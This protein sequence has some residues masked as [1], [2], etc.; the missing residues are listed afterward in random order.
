MTA[1]AALRP[2]ARGPA[3]ARGGHR[4]GVAGRRPRRRR[5]RRP[6]GRLP[7]ASSA[8]TRD[9]EDVLTVWA[10]SLSRHASAGRDGRAGIDS[11]A[12]RGRPG[13]AR[14]S[15][16]AG[17][18]SGRPGRRAGRPGRGLPERSGA[19]PDPAVEP[20]GP[21]PRG[22]EGRR[23][24]RSA[25]LR[26]A[27]GGDRDRVGLGGGR[28]ASSR[29]SGETLA[30]AGLY[31]LEVDLDR[32]CAWTER[33]LAD[34]ARQGAR[35]THEVAADLPASRAAICSAR[36]TASGGATAK[37]G[38]GRGLRPWAAVDGGRRR[39]DDDPGGGGLR[40]A[41][42]DPFPLRLEELLQA[43]EADDRPPGCDAPR[44]A[45]RTSTACRSRG[46]AWSRW[47]RA[48]R[49]P[50]RL[51]R[52]VAKS[53]WD[54]PSV[55]RRISKACRSRGSAASGSPCMIRRRAS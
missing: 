7:V 21:P 29:S 14:G 43:L 26:E 16:R 23:A 18:R 2:H 1:G 48:Q 47:P 25:R 46:S 19:G 3:G 51:L 39:R 27:A 4:E 34:A 30:D 52:F 12:A 13:L 15:R 55:A 31:A 6:T 36:S 28:A 8:V 38:R 45:N 44:V 33:A 32:E 22:A 35:R 41:E 53:G 42:P 50:P 37:R 11:I 17:R 40:G 10:P 9:E 5:T 49:R 54:S 24:A 20:R